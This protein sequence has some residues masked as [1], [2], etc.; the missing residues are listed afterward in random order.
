VG[1]ERRRRQSGK[2]AG[3]GISGRIVVVFIVLVVLLI[4]GFVL[5]NSSFLAITEIRVEGAQRLTAQRLTDLAAVPAGST[6]LRVDTNGISKRLES[7]SWVATARIDRAFP[8]AVVLAIE[9]RQIVAVVEIPPDQPTGTTEHWLIANDGVWLDEWVSAGPGSSETTQSEQSLFDDVLVFSS[10]LGDIPVIKDVAR[11]LKPVVGA[12]A[13]DEGVLNAVTILNGF[14][15]EMRDQ[16]ASISAPDRVK[17]ELTLRNYVHVAF[18]DGED[19]V[20][21]EAAILALLREH[22]GSITYIN[23]RVADRATYRVAE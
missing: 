3:R 23:V 18:G 11:T 14:T 8:S 17:T 10:E 15:A 1:E 12:A 13:E 7:D 4:G 19:I 2:P 22:E 16:V 20:G 6:L 21:K 5:Y 9:E